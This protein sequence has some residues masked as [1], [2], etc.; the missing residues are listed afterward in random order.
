MTTL[1]LQDTAVSGEVDLNQVVG[2]GTDEIT[3][4]TR[5][6]GYVP[7]LF[8]F[9]TNPAGNGHFQIGGC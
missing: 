2:Q 8:H 3:Q 6:D 4:Q 5:G 9:G 1:K 7:L